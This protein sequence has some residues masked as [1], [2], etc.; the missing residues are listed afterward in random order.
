MT[1][2][3]KSMW[4]VRD[5][6]GK[7]RTVTAF[8]HAGAVKRYIAEHDPPDGEILDVKRRGEDPDGEYG[9]RS[10]KVREE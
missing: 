7:I 10:Y 8:S 1:K 9:W 4:Q 3:P 5:A 2:L 6:G